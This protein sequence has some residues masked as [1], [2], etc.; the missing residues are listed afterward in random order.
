MNVQKDI[1]SHKTVPVGMSDQFYLMWLIEVT[2][3]SF[4]TDTRCDGS[5]VAGFW[6]TRLSDCIVTTRSP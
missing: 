5:E 2:D 1:T 4:I 6:V 3:P